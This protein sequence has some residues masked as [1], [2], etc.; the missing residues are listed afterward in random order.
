MTINNQEFIDGSW[1]ENQYKTKGSI[2]SS[3]YIEQETPKWAK[4]MY[5][6]CSDLAIAY[7]GINSDGKILDLGSGVGNYVRAFQDRNFDTHGIEISSEAVKLSNNEKII[8]GSIQNMYFFKDKQF[9]LVFS[10]ALFEHLDNSIVEKCFLECKRISDIQIHL[11]SQDR[12]HDPSHIN[13]KKAEEWAW[14]LFSLTTDDWIFLIPNLLEKDHPIIIVYSE[15]KPMPYHL[16]RLVQ[17]YNYNKEVI[18][19][20]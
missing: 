9:D 5:R 16:E 19:P 17:S 3:I 15:N 2:Y 14:E 18:I 11:I 8:C 7:S 10:A 20:K 6:H 1:Y 13:I 12:G 4:Q